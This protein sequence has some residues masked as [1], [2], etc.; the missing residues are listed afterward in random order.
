MSQPFNPYSAEI[1]FIRQ[2]LTNKVN[3]RTVSVNIFIMIVDPEHRYSNESERASSDIYDDFK[4]KKPI[5]VSM[6][7]TK[8]FQRCKS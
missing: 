4:L 6:F 8:I 3:P 1:D 2:I 7:Y 5:L